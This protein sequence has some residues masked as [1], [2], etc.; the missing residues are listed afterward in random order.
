MRFAPM[1]CSLRSLFALLQE[2]AILLFVAMFVVPI[3]MFHHFPRAVRTMKFSIRELLLVTVIVALALGWW[4]DRS[5]VAKR[6]RDEVTKAAREVE[7]QRAL[8][9]ALTRQLQNK[10]PAASIDIR[11]RGSSS[12]TSTAYGAK[13]E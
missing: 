7:S 3:D 10:N 13:P 11:I 9:E 4:L 2:I 5:R 12:T 8:S 6:A 1:K